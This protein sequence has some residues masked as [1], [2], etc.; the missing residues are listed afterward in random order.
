MIFEKG[1]TELEKLRQFP[2]ADNLFAYFGARTSEW[3]EPI[4]YM[5]CFSV[6]VFYDLQDSFKNESAFQLLDIAA[7]IHT[8]QIS[9]ERYVRFIDLLSTLAVN[10][11][12]TEMPQQLRQ[13]FTSLIE[14]AN[15]VAPDSIGLLSLKRHYRVAS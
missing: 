7:T 14:R 15:R 1:N 11:N 13:V 6:S 12:T 10:T 9:D 2:N 4:I 3:C 8:D 5:E